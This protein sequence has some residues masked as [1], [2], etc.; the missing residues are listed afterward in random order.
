MKKV[1]S[2]SLIFLLLFNALGF[3]GLLEGLR[4]KT[5][6]DLVKRLDNHRYTEDETILLKIPVAVPYKMDSEDY[7]RVDG[8]FEHNGEFYRLVKQ[9]YQN[10]TLFMVCIKDHASKRIERALTDYV[11]TFTDKPVD[12]QHTGKNFTSFIKDF[13]PTSIKISTTSKGWN[14]TVASAFVEHYFYDRPLKVFTPPPQ[15]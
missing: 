11:K 6:I 8:E 13:L 1:V 2:I 7:E 9:K 4:Y 15:S 3:Y 12:R 5:T 14:Y 10:D